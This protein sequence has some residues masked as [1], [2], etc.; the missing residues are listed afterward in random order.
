MTVGQTERDRHLL[1]EDC[2]MNSTYYTS[3]EEKLG[4]EESSCVKGSRMRKPVSPPLTEDL[5]LAE[6]RVKLMKV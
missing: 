6:V 3:N 2:G 1:N 5:W 4:S